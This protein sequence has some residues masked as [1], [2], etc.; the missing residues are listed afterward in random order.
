MSGWAAK[1][2]WTAADVAEV[3]GEG[4]GGGGFTVQLDGRPVKT[5]ARAALVVPT[6]AMAQAIAAEWD[7]QEGKVD[8]GSMPVTR[9]A[10]AAIDKV[11]H[12]HAE[13]A[14]LIA[15]YGDSDHI[16][17]RAEAPAELV[18][19]Q[20]EGWDP[21][22]DWAAAEFGGRLIP[23]QGVMHSPQPAAALAPM[24]AAVHAMDAFTLTAFHDLVSLSGSLVIGF[25]ALRD[26]AAP[27]ALWALSRID[28]KWQA[29]LWGA[30]DE[31][32]ALAA[33]KESDFLHAKRFYDLARRVN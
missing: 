12:Q 22:L 24:T 4:K 5:P 25:A 10:N 26:H 32:E 27:D 20:A 23:V 30:D 14:G 2:F 33:R 18:R 17:Y 8:P 6:R 19:R 7:A 9:S 1:R 16:C 13:V 15:A 31:A 21:L 29:E 3:E 28:E 11:T